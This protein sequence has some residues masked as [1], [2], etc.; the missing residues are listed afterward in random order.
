MVPVAAKA[1]GMGSSEELVVFGVRTLR[2]RSRLIHFQDD[3]DLCR[4]M[5][6]YADM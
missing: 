5:Q 3:A 2:A 4:S 6:I 1:L